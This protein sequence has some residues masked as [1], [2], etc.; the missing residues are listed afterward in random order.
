[1]NRFRPNIVLRGLEAFEEDHVDTFTIGDVTLRPVKPCTRCQVTTTD[2]VTAVVGIEP[3]RAL[4]AY[5]M[6]V[7]LGGLAFGMNAIVER[8]GTLAAGM[9]VDV[10]LRF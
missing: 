4:G 5:R 1:M 2:Q 7:G 6:H 9:P 3:L 8:E 10:S